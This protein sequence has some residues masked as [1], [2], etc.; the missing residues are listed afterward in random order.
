MSLVSAS[1][2]I[3][4]IKYWGKLPNIDD[5][6]LNL[7]TNPSLSMT[8]SRAKTETRFEFL[9]KT[10]ESSILIQNVTPS[11][12]D[13]SKITKHVERV[14]QAFEHSHLNPFSLK[15]FN[16]FPQGTGLASSASAFCALTLAVASEIM[17]PEQLKR[18]Y[19]LLLP[20]LSALARR[21]SGSACRSLGGPFMLWRGENAQVFPADFKLRDTIL[22][23]SKE[24]KKV[25][26]TE[27]HKSAQSSPLFQERLDHLERRLKAVE[28]AL[29]KKDLQELGPLLEAEAL[30]LH[31][32]AQTG[33]PPIQYLLPESLQFLAEMKNL[34][35]REFFF[36][37]DAGPNVHLISEKRILPQIETLLAKLG[38]KCEIWEDDQGFGPQF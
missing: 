14:C 18:D 15:S 8:L 3:A 34:K 36:T 5:L 30:E 25:P 6:N 17:G 27:G 16:N 13:I 12:N 38:L 24:H 21:G 33:N 32:I 10:S 23:F 31:E 1:P 9:S 37:L 7:A 28:A 20:K 35:E 11:Q 29:I 2:N 26:S 4:L 19:W 22:I